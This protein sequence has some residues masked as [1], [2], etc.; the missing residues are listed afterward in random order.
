LHDLANGN[1]VERYAY[2]MTGK[3][4]I[5]APNGTTVRTNSSYGNNFG[6]TSSWHDEE[7]GLMYFRARYYNPLTGEFLRRD[8]AGFVDGMSLYRGYMDVNYVDP[9]GLQTVRCRCYSGWL[10]G[11]VIGSTTDVQVEC[12]RVLDD[13]CKKACSK[14]GGWTG[15]Y[16]AQNTETVSYKKWEDYL[17]TTESLHPHDPVDLWLTRAKL[18]SFGIAGVS[19]GGAGITYGVSTYGWYGLGAIVLK[20]AGDAAKDAALESTIGFSPP[21][22]IRGGLKSVRD[23]F[24]TKPFKEWA[25]SLTADQRRE[26]IKKKTEAEAMRRLN[27]RVRQNGG[28]IYGHLPDP[29]TVTEGGNFSRKQRIDIYA[30]NREMHGGTL[31][32]DLDGSALHIDRHGN[33]LPNF[34]DRDG[35]TPSPFQPA[36]DHIIPRKPLDPTVIPGKN[37]TANARVLSRCQNGD[38]SNK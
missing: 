38:K 13:C 25:S 14:L 1:V 11:D 26:L 34:P 19:L 32:S 36:V 6:Y 23:F 22:G 27:E 17:L 35:V 18:G 10:D 9:S 37:S 29:K 2:D 3:R 20:E 12:N 4:T 31:R 28:S 7:S 15:T 24:G 21:T 30:S 16:T 33:P 5:Y 8:P